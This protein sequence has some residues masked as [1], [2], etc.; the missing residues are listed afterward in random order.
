MQL[1]YTPVSPYARKVIMLAKLLDLHDLELVRVNPLVDDAFRKINP[2]GKVPV[3]IDGDM[4][5]FES[6]LIAE[7][8]DDKSSANGGK[9]YFQRN[10]PSYYAIQRAHALADG[11]LDA[12]VATVM[13]LRRKDAEHSAFWLERWHVGMVHAIENM[14]TDSLGTSDQIHIGTIA[15]VSA[16]GYLDFRLSP[17]N[18]R[19]CNP[20]LR[21][22]YDAMGSQPWVRATVPEDA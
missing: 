10:T 19:E 2:L 4:S 5:L 8:L 1:Y 7:Y 9:S 13:E 16:L 15:T 11:V 21:D 3:L 17:L 14:G 20:A 6:H 18:W 12:A 22:W